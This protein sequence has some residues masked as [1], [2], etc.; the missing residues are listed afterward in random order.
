MPAVIA[1]RRSRIVLA[2]R[3]SDRLLENSSAK[4]NRGMKQGEVLSIAVSAAAD[5]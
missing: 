1:D 2:N 5:Q 4:L 3:E